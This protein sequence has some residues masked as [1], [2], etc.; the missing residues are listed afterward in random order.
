MTRTTFA[1]LLTAVAA[2]GSLTCTRRAA[3]SPLTAFCGRPNPR[4]GS[5]TTARARA[6]G[7]A[8]C[9]K[10]RRP[11][12]TL[13]SKWVLQNQ[14]FSAWQS[15]RL[16]STGHVPGRATE[17]R[18]GRG[19]RDRPCTGCIAGHRR[20]MRASVAVP[21]IAASRFSATRCSWVRSMAISS[22]LTRRT[23]NRSGTSPSRTSSSPTPSRSR[24]SSSRTRSL[25]ASVAAG[26]AFAGSLPPSIEERQG[27][28]ALQRRARP[29]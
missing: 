10:S 6:S 4:T 16:W 1:S 8:R 23:A 28:L 11:T 19:R 13:E 29:R 21:T 14:V 15:N 7:T 27:A 20:R 25:S 26:S 24:R 18:H 3:R 9:R 12:K 22:R 5:P 2:V 17:R